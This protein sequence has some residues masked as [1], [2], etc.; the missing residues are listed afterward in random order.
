MV[1][2]VLGGGRCTGWWVVYWMVGGGQPAAAATAG[3]A[4][5]ADAVASPA[6]PLQV[7][8]APEASKFF[9]FVLIFG[10]TLMMFTAYGIMCINLT[11]EMGLAGLFLS[12]FFGF[13]NLL[14]GFL[15]AQ[16]FIPG[17]W[18]WCACRRGGGGVGAPVVD[19]MGYSEYK[20]R[21]PPHRT[22]PAP[23]CTPSHFCRCYWINP[24]AYTLYGLIVTQLG[25]L[26]TTYVTDFTGA[27]VT[28]PAFLE[29]R[30]GYKY[31]MRVPIV[32]ILLAFVLTFR[33]SSVRQAAALGG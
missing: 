4:A 6:R 10:L 25:D 5:V 21:T 2:G 32:F 29:Q 15:I 28:V 14:C 16:P 1:G 23:R 31:D 17:W 13:W 9:W 12:F 8:F 3:S 20:P 24:I 22:H 19:L 18:I 11:P 30:F 26:T 7:G 33:L 27:L